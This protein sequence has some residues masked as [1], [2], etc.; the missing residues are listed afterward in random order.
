MLKKIPRSDLKEGMRFSAPIFFEDGENML[1]TK[2]VPLKNRELQV[3]DRWKMSYVLTAGR[4][5]ADTEIVDTA[6]EPED[7]EDLDEL[8]ELEEEEPLSGAALI[9]SGS[10]VPQHGIQSS[11]I[12]HTQV[13]AQH[14]NAETPH[15]DSIEYTSEQ[16]LKLPEVLENNG[17]YQRYTSLVNELDTVFSRIKQQQ[18]IRTRAI[19]KIVSELFELVQSERAGI[20][21]FILGGDVVEK[22][23]AKCAINTAI[24]S[25]IIAEQ[26]NLPRHRHLQVA[27]GAVLHDV[28]M[29]KIPESIISKEGSL[30][31]AE[32]QSMRSHTSYGYKLIVQ[33]L[34]Y[35]DEVGRAAAQ[36]H[37]RWDGEGYPSRLSGNSIDIGARII[38]VADAFEAMVSPKSY[39][40]SMVGYQAMK[41]LLSDN[42]RRFDPEIIKAMV[43]SMGI[44][45]VGSIVLLNNSTIARV[46]ESHREAPLRPVIRVLIDEFA[47]PYTLNEGDTLDLLDNRNLFI[48]R[49]IDPAEYKHSS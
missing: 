34:L 11:S 47:K 32:M 16:I 39:R 35:A 15:L 31:D 17:L 19:D 4:P 30:D 49:A 38:S 37:E 13:R 23:Q 14:Q 44:Y 28:G 21:G 27:T 22:Q 1:V 8:E 42:A 33:E 3:L 24:L 43:Q 40:K 48:A 36:H 18:D 5:I 7:L 25:I 46:I 45:P 29:L 26:L 20:A 10:S 41:N 9:P 12:S 6:E 2:G